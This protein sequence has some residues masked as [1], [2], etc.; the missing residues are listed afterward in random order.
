[1][2]MLSIRPQ[3]IIVC[4]CGRNR[5]ICLRQEAILGPALKCPYHV[6]F[7][8]DL[9]FE[10]A[11]D[12]GAPVDHCSRAICLGEE[13]FFVQAQKCP[14]HVI[15]DIDLDFEHALDAGAPVD[16]RVQF[17]SQSGLW[18]LEEAIFVIGTKVPISRDL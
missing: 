8:L 7:D 18:L 5:A 2:T 11:L 1:M 4:K 13:A 10:H 16:H 14:Y 6:T 3:E 12:A 15:F 9:D 17:W